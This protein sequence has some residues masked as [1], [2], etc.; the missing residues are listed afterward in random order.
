M[1]GMEELLFHV[2]GMTASLVDDVDFPNTQL[3][4]VGTYRYGTTLGAAKTVPSYAVCMPITREQF[5]EALSGGFKLMNYRK[6]TTKT[7]EGTNTKI[8]GTPVP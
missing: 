1:G 4:C 7:P 8:V 2:K 5:A 6:V 3:V